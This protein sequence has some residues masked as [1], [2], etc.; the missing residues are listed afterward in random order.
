[1]SGSRATNQYRYMLDAFHPVRNPDGYYPRSS[2]EYCFVPS[3]LQIHD[4]TYLRLKNASVSYTFDLKKSKIFK[5]L[6]LTLSGDNLLLWTAYN[7][8]DPDVSTESDNST[9]RRVDLGAYPKSRTVML[10]VTLK[11]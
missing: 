6:A 8:F 5:N 7:G 10:G 11:M 1:M 9:L 2:T 4:A 3:T